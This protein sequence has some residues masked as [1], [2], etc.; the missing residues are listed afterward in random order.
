MQIHM[1]KTRITAA[2]KREHING[3]K[4]IRKSKI[5]EALDLLSKTMNGVWNNIT[6]SQE[7]LEAWPLVGDV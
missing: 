3:K 6:F 4:K 1:Y 7:H 5:G 2:T